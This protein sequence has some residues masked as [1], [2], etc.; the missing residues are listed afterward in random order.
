[1]GVSVLFVQNHTVAAVIPSKFKDLRGKTDSDA[2]LLIAEK[3]L[4]K[5]F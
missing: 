1:M 3:I 5:L 4:R 2:L